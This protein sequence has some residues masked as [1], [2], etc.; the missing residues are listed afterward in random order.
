MFILNIADVKRTAQN[1][2]L[3][4]SSCADQ[5]HN[6]RPKSPKLTPERR[7]D[8]A[9]VDETSDNA[10]ET[11]AESSKPFNVTKNF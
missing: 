1:H 3:D 2:P 10:T 4:R 6:N 9:R 8:S 7:G 5:V 11:G